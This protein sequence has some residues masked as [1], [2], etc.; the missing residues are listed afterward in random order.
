MIGG[1]IYNSI[2]FMILPLYVSLEKIDPRLLEASKDLYSSAFRAFTQGHPAAVAAR[3]DR[4]QHAGV[5]PGRR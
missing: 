4:R 1:L 3:R 5:H 2:I